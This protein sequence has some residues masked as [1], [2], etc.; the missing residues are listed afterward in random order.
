MWQTF[1]S[2]QLFSAIFIRMEWQCGKIFTVFV[3]IIL[4]R[5]IEIEVTSRIVFLFSFFISFSFDRAV[6]LWRNEISLKPHR[7]QRKWYG[8]I[9]NP[10]TVGKQGKQSEKPVFKWYKC[11]EFT[12]WGIFRTRWDLHL[13]ECDFQASGQQVRLNHILPPVLNPNTCTL[14]KQPNRGQV[15]FNLLLE[16]NFE[17]HNPWSVPFESFYCVN[18]R[19]FVSKII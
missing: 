10:F 8:Q 5:T 7:G 13:F 2:I 3:F 6:F 19:K 15:L 9:I 18:F 17:H 16:I 12:I 14:K 1:I 11:E 4:Y